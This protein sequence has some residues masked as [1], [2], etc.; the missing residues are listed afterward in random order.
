MAVSRPLPPRARPMAMRT[1][2]KLGVHVGGP[3]PPMSCSQVKSTVSLGDTVSTE[4]AVSL[5]DFAR[6]YSKSLPLTVEAQH[7][8]LG[9]ASERKMTISAGDAMNIHFVRHTQVFSIK[10]LRSKPFNV[11]LNSSVQFGLLYDPNDNLEEAKQ[12]FTYKKVSDLTALDKLPKVVCAK[13]AWKGKDKDISKNEIL[14]LKKHLTSARELKV[15]SV[16]CSCEK[17]LPQE[18]RGHFTTSPSSVA[19]HLHELAPHLPEGALPCKALSLSHLIP[20]VV[21]LLEQG[22]ETT[23]VASNVLDKS[24]TFVDIPVDLPGVTV[25]IVE[26]SFEQKQGLYHTTKQFVDHFDPSKIKSFGRTASHQDLL[27]TAA[28]EGYEKVGVEIEVSSDICGP[29]PFSPNPA[30]K[31]VQ[32]KVSDLD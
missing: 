3:T 20:G 14:V 25:S 28:K 18:C 19:L 16:A 13:K 4:C 2:S 24:Q 9:G 22:I 15:F 17:T 11:P 23:L 32:L 31:R 12:G 5:A 6:K 26:S 21:M 7:G 1:D 27:C 29:I 30:Y 10:S 8:E